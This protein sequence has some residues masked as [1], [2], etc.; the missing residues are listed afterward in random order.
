MKT[1]S[2]IY[3][4]IDAPFKTKKKEKCNWFTRRYRREAL[5]WGSKKQAQA[6]DEFRIKTGWEV[7]D[8]EKGICGHNI[9]FRPDGIICKPTGEKILLE[10]KCPY[11]LRMCYDLRTFFKKKKTYWYITKTLFI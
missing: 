2:S 9:L 1:A 8:I 11:R 4:H 7:T 10:I 6:L 5:A 3:L